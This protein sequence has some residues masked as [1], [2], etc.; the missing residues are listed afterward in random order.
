MTN[1]KLL[2]LHIALSWAIAG[3][4]LAWGVFQTV[5]KSLPLFA[6]H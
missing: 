1:S 6:A 2:P 5:L 4:P 3:L